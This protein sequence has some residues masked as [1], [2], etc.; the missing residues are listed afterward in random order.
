MDPLDV[1]LEL[2]KVKPYFQAIFSADSHEVIGYEVLGRIEID[3]KVKSLGGFFHDPTVPDEFKIEVDQHIQGLAL[4]KFIENGQDSLLFLNIQ[5]NYLSNNIDNNFIDKFLN[6]QEKGLDLTNVVLEI[7]EH[8]FSGD[9]S[10]LSNTLKYL[11]TMGIKIAIDDLGT[12]ASNLDR[13]SLLEPDIL[14]VDLLALQNETM[15]TAYHGVIYSLSLL[16]R[17]L[18][19]ELLFEGVET[20]YQFHY[21]WRKNGRYYQGFF[22]SEPIASFINKNILKEKFRKDIHQFISIE[23]EN[24]TKQYALSQ[25]LSER[26]KKVLDKY[27]KT[28]DLDDRLVEIAKELNDVCFRIYLTDFEGFQTTSNIIRMDKEWTVDQTVRGKN[29]SWR[30]YFIQNLIR[31]QDEKNGILSD[32]YNDIETGEMIRT[33][34]YPVSDGLFLFMD[35]PHIYLDDHQYLLW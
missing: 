35:I 8:D 17:K 30:P 31:M 6:Y 32:V 16:A 5:A 33:F 27:K 26:L 13:I 2:K 25:E 29:W 11:K 1:M 3:N 12:G 23:R 34:S 22:L 20:A 15:S 21:A 28:K 14:K 7:T 4:E 19:A 18:G 9:L 24:L 10:S